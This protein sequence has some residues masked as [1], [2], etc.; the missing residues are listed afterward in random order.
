MGRGDG[1]SGVMSEDRRPRIADAGGPSDDAIDRVSPSTKVSTRARVRRLFDFW[2]RVYCRP[3][4]ETHHLSAAPS[5]DRGLSRAM[6]ATSAA[7]AS[8]S[9]DDPPFIVVAPPSGS[10]PWDVSVRLRV[11]ELPAIVLHE[12]QEPHRSPFACGDVR[13]RLA[14]YPRS[15]ATGA[16]EARRAS[17]PGAARR[18]AGEFGYPRLRGG[19]VRRRARDGRARG[20]PPRWRASRSRPSSRS[21]NRCDAPRLREHDTRARDDRVAIPIATR[22][23]TPPANR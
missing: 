16:N 15:T 5:G 11:D 3:R 12:S 22:P 7:S 2:R 6:A 8:T 18:S 17:D 4:H 14:V 21:R 20:G 10:D 9:A 23:R 19:R 1:E 13:W